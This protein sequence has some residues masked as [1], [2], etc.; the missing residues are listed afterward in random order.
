VA[1]G[2]G[3]VIYCNGIPIVWATTDLEIVALI[4][5]SELAAASTTISTTTS[6]LSPTIAASPRSTVT[7][8][9]NAPK[10][11]SASASGPSTSEISP[12]SSGHG[13]SPGKIAGAVIGAFIL[14]LIAVSAAMGAFIYHRHQ[15]RKTK[16][17]YTSEAPETGANSRG[18][19][20]LVTNANTPELLGKAKRGTEENEILVE[21]KTNEMRLAQGASTEDRDAGPQTPPVPPFPPKIPF[22]PPKDRLTPSGSDLSHG[23]VPP[24]KDSVPT[25]AYELSHE[26]VP[27]NHE[28]GGDALYELD[29]QAHLEEILPEWVTRA[30]LE[31]QRATELSASPRASPV[32]PIPPLSSTRHSISRKPVG[33]PEPSNAMA[34]GPSDHG[35]V[36]TGEQE[37]AR[38]A[39]LRDRIERIRA[40]KERLEQI[41]RLSQLEE[42]TKTEILAAAQR[43]S[44]PN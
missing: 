5:S 38:L 24:P 41:Q 11:S 3:N 16:E 18:P 32:Q 4:T 19:H 7:S 39:L 2:I 40:E 31:A 13:T 37:E 6:T 35:D 15:R 1:A 44:K 23:T 22:P 25:V 27:P 43:R 34:A 33:S 8:N 21:E 30:E 42:E 29:P 14:G 20:E 10:S 9:G 17:K 26:A 28:L 36:E 12:L